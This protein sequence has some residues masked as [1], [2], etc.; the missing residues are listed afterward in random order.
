MQ[1]RL[2]ITIDTGKKLEIQAMRLS[3]MQQHARN[4]PSSFKKRKIERANCLLYKAI[5]VVCNAHNQSC[6]SCPYQQYNQ[7]TD[8]MECI[9]EE[10]RSIALE[11]AKNRGAW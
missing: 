2:V 3:L 6:C 1:V 4:L 8:T 10:I 7:D 5:D 9:L 11:D